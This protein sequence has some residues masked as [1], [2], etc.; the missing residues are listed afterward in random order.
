MRA[1][2][3]HRHRITID[4]PT[5]ANPRGGDR[6]GDHGGCRQREEGLA[7]VGLNNAG[8]LTHHHQAGRGREKKH[9]EEAYEYVRTPIAHRQRRNR[10]VVH[11]NVGEPHQSGR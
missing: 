5:T 10:S 9:G 4:E 1:R 2:R 8:R 11:A 6:T 3:H 7:A